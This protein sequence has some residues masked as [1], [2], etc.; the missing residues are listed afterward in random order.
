MLDVMMSAS[1]QLE[2]QKPL[3]K[4]RVS[5]SKR[6]SHQEIFEKLHLK[7]WINCNTSL[8]KMVKHAE[9]IRRFVCAGLFLNS[10]IQ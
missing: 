4:T 9:L 5:R 7:K 1:A 8:K 2:C 3:G 6:P 10:T